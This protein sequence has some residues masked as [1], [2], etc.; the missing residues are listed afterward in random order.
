MQ[1]QNVNEHKTPAPR[2]AEP[3]KTAFTDQPFELN[4]E[5]YVCTDAGVFTKS[6]KTVCLHP[7]LPAGGISD[8]E[9]RQMSLKIAFNASGFWEER[10]YPRTLLA[11]PTAILSLSAAG[12][13]VTAENARLLSAYLTNLYH[14]NS[15]LL[16]QQ[17]SVPHLGWAN[18][19]SNCFVPFSE[20]VVCDGEEAFRTK[21]DAVRFSGDEH[22]WAEAVAPLWHGS[23]PARLVISASFAS[24]LLTPL[25]LQP[26]FLHL[27]G[28]TGLGKTVLLQLAASVWGDPAPG[29]LITTFN[30]TATGLELTAAFLHDIPML[31]DELQ[32]A[33]SAGKNDFQQLVYTLSEGVGRTR[34]AK[35]GGLRRQ[36][37]WRSVMITTGERPLSTELSGGGALNRCIEIELTEPVTKD[38]AGLMKTVSVNFGAAGYRFVQEADRRRELLPDILEGYQADLV[39]CGVS[40]KQ[41]AAM[42]ALML[43]D[44]MCGYLF[45]KQ[46][47]E[48]TPPLSAE[49]VSPLLLQNEQVCAEKRALEYLFDT[50]AANPAHFPDTPDPKRPVEIWGRMGKEYTAVIGTVFNRIMEEGGF[51]PRAVLAYA[52]R[53]GLLKR[54]DAHLRIN[55]KILNKTVRCVVIKQKQEN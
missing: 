13:A 9:T 42:A 45:F 39:S 4:C 23:L 6:G 21:L 20:N 50:I 40:G 53:E 16:P 8:C 22:K 47:G 12:V 37:T 19:Y 25:D 49:E 48:P 38:F 54:D 36:P 7:I 31:I 2:E 3:A 35:D 1:T 24:A 27:W 26:F 52:D 33:S 11:S 46:N 41:A 28:C 18:R 43:A 30:A 29:K 10:T 44:G 55:V 15:H 14:A 17:W 32:I 5:G 51:S 34:G